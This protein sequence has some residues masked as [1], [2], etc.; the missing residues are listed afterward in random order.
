MRAVRWGLT[1]EVEQHDGGYLVTIQTV[2]A[3]GVL[4]MERRLTVTSL[5]QLPCPRRFLCGHPNVAI[6]V[7]VD[8]GRT[9]QGVGYGLED[10]AEDGLVLFFLAEVRGQP[11]GEEAG[12]PLLEHLR[13]LLGARV[14]R[15]RV[16]DHL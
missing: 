9:L 11:R 15:A 14:V 6:A 7:D 2:G 5:E 3:D 13:H 10:A 12:L 16:D 1:V 8:P 4:A